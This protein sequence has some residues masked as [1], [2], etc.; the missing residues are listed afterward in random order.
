MEPYVQRWGTGKHRE[1][2]MERFAARQ[3]GRKAAR[4]RQVKARRKGR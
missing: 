4:K 2:R 3:R 1:A